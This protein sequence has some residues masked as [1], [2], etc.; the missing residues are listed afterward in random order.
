V[1]YCIILY[2]YISVTLSTTATIITYYKST[3]YGYYDLAGYH[4]FIS[5]PVCYNTLALYWNYHG[6]YTSTSVTYSSWT[7]SSISTLYY[8]T[9]RKYTVATILPY[10]TCTY[11]STNVT[12]STT[13]TYTLG[14]KSTVYGYYDYATLTWTIKN[15]ASCYNT[16]DW[17]YITYYSTYTYSSYQ[18]CI[19]LSST[20]TMY[21]STTQSYIYTF[22]SNTLTTSYSPTYT[23][24]L[25]I[26]TKNTIANTNSLTYYTTNIQY[27]T[28]TRVMAPSPSLLP[29]DKCTCNIPL[30]NKLDLVLLT[31][32]NIV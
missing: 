18:W 15:H 23:N 20:S 4:W 11:I 30:C 19:G 8:S 14:Y 3:T 5:N 31:I 25:I 28:I 2:L 7:Y 24:S 32:N 12:L 22:L 9:T 17:K 26:S 10:T 16:L 13:Q 21:Y 6:S 27:S 1:Q 29:K